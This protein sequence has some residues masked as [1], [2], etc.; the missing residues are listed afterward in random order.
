MVS[1]VVRAANKRFFAERQ[2][3]ILFN[4]QPKAPACSRKLTNMALS[5]HVL[6]RECDVE[7]PDFLAFRRRGRYRNGEQSDDSSWE[8]RI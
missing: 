1:V 2:A 7:S 4:A 6:D 8:V 3:T 5:P